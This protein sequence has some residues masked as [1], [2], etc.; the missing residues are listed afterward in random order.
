MF[1]GGPWWHEEFSE[2]AAGDSGFTS[3]TAERVAWHADYTDAYC[4]NPYYWFSTPNFV[5]RFKAARSLFPYLTKVHNDDL[6]STNQ[7]IN[8]QYRYMTGC[9]IGLH[10]AA[11]IYENKYSENIDPIGA[12]HNILGVTFHALQDFYSH[13]NWIDEVS[14]RD[15]TFLDIPSCEIETNYLYTGSYEE[16]GG[17]KSHGKFSI[18][19]SVTGGAFGPALTFSMDLYCSA[20][21]PFSNDDICKEYRDCNENDPTNVG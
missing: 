16:D 15:K 14:R 4:Y 1:T 18:I 11:E 6:F 20:L 12:A 3:L 5:Q 2:Y 8:A 19:C 7:V 17:P 21:S 9:L 13:S 10:W